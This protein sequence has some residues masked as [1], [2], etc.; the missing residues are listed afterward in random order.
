MAGLH[1]VSLDGKTAI[2]TG[3]A[4]GNRAQR[5]SPLALAEAGADVVGSRHHDSR[6]RSISIADIERKAENPSLGRSALPRRHG[7]PRGRRCIILLRSDAIRNSAAPGQDHWVTNAGGSLPRPLPG[8][9][10]RGYEPSSD[11]LKSTFPLLPGRP[12]L[13]YA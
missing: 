5:E 4:P 9:S 1:E 8:I 3:P 11:N 13:C 6:I 12:E 7:P 10:A 2:V